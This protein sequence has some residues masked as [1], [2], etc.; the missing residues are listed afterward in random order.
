EMLTGRPPFE[1]ITA[2]ETE[3]RV[4]TEEPAPPSRFNEKIPRD[5]ETICLKCLQKN[6]ARR[7]ASAQDLADD[8]HRFLDGKPVL[9]RPVGGL[10]RPLKWMRRQPT[11]AI[12]LAVLCV[13]L[14]AGA[15]T[16]VVFWRQA[17]LRQ[18]EISYRRDR[19]QPAVENGI[20][21]AY[22]AA[23]AERWDE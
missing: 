14:V 11:L 22:E 20:K 9:A 17:I 7:Y 19:A 23:R 16:A 13:A 10:E 15:V 4:I 5:L 12:L 6:P 2:A 8:L 3:N 18:A 1:G 21:Y